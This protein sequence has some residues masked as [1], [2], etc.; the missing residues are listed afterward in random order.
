M[1]IVRFPKYIHTIHN[2]HLTYHTV[3]KYFVNH[4]INLHFKDVYDANKT[5]LSSALRCLCSR[6]L[7]ILVLLTYSLCYRPVL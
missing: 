4:N 6:K 1:H 2:T 5:C 7:S 3:T